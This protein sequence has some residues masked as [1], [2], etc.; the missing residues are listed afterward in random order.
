MMFA[1]LEWVMVI[2]AVVLM[3][4]MAD[5]ENYSTFLWGAGTFEPASGVTAPDPADRKAIEAAR[6]DP[7]RDRFVEFR[8]VQDRGAGNLPGHQFAS[9]NHTHDLVPLWAMGAG[10]HL[11]RQFER[12]DAFAQELWGEPYG[13]DGSYVDNTAVF[14]VM[15]AALTSPAP[16][17][18]PAHTAADR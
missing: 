17:R 4:R 11:F 14:H 18:Q 15:H 3:V 16:A 7:G 2:A 12:H 9:G 1:I 5:V 6:F 10:A 8:A 13:W